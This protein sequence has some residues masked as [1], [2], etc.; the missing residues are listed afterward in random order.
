MNIA[1]KGSTLIVKKKNSVAT[2][3]AAKGSS[4]DD[5][6]KADNAGKRKA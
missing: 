4:P 3:T 1:R 2:S 6:E 5:R